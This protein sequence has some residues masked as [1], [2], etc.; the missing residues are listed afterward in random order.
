MY[1]NAFGKMLLNN[2]QEDND[3]RRWVGYLGGMLFLLIVALCFVFLN[4]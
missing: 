1:D 3:I 4:F 2:K